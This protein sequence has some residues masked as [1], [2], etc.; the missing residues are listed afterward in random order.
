MFEKKWLGLQLKIVSNLLNRQIKQIAAH[1]EE[2]MPCAMSG[3]HGL[4]IAYL[5]ENSDKNIYQRDIEKLLSIR[6]SS[7]T[8]ILQSMEKNG[9][10]RRVSVSHDAR[11]KK[12]IIT[13]Q[14]QIHYD[15]ITKE[16]NRIE[17]QLVQ[18]ISEAEIEQFR[19]TLTKLYYNIADTTQDCEE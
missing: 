16:I 11:L 1:S 13:E 8:S 19:Q 10:I 4:I 17:S 14:G 18:N 5:A 2:E 15:Y 7:V 6:R 12:I 3:L 9:L